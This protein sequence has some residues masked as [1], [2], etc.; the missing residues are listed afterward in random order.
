M[1]EATRVEVARRIAARRGWRHGALVGTDGTVKVPEYLIGL[2]C[3]GWVVGV[4]RTHERV[5]VA[6]AEVAR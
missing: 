3:F 4:R 5:G 6:G 2:G 1:G